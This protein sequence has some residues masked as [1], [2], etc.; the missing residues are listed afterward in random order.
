M[1]VDKD[2]GTWDDRYLSIFVLRENKTDEVF[3][4]KME[5]RFSVKNKKLKGF[6]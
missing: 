4:M 5:G 2:N 6:L 3:V 1:Y